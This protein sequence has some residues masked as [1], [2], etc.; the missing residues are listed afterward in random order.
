MSSFKQGV[1]LHDL[2]F[3]LLSLHLSLNVDIGLMIL[4]HCLAR[5]ST[6]GN[7]RYLSASGLL[8]LVSSS[9]SNRSML[10]D[11][12]NK[13][14]SNYVYNIVLIVHST[15]GEADE[16]RQNKYT[17]R[18]EHKAA[19]AKACQSGYNRNCLSFFCVFGELQT[20]SILSLCVSFSP[21]AGNHL[22]ITY[23]L[24][25]IVVCMTGGRGKG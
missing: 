3:I 12:S 25:S 4:P 15:A 7:C 13:Q 8:I 11:D 1:L 24:A 19:A 2:P 10:V 9:S 22:A 17:E 16:A 18:S 6:S 14:Y 5:L 20:H 23:Q 21:V